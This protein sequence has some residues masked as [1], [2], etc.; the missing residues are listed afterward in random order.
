MKVALVTGGSRGIG[1]SCCK[2]LAKDG[3]SVVVNYRSG[4]T[5]ADKVVAEIEKEGGKACAIQAD[6]GV[7][8]DVIKLF[9]EIDAWDGGELSALV[10]NAGVL[11]PSGS[12]PL[13]ELTADDMEVIF[14]TNCKGPLYCCKEAEK[15]M[16]TKMGG[17]GGVIVNLSSGSANFGAPLIYGMSKAAINSMQAGLLKPFGEA[18]IRMNSISPG[19]TIKTLYPHHHCEPTADDGISCQQESPR[20]T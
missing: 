12:V 10:N 9:K 4:A 8:S 14:N 15:R 1:A 16:S 7:E 2:L 19:K 3:F 13:Q 17:K 6:V 18:G 20:P 11:G 5:A